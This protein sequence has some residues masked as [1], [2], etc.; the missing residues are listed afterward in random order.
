MVTAAHHFYWIRP[1]CKK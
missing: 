1:T